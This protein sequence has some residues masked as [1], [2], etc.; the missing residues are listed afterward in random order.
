MKTINTDFISLEVLKTLFYQIHYHQ[1][2]ERLYSIFRTLQDVQYRG[3][4]SELCRMFS[5]VE[6][7]QYFEGYL[8]LWRILSTVLDTMSTLEGVQFFLSDV[9]FFE[10]IIST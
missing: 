3:G 10:D 9:Q 6:D 7:V 2:R 5:T 8:V 4:C 1:P